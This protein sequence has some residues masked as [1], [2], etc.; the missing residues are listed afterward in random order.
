MTI[1]PKLLIVFGYLCTTVLYAQ[2]QQMVDSLLQAAQSKN[3]HD[4]TKIKAYNDLGIQYA[5]TDSELARVYIN[6]ALHLAKQIKKER[7]IAGAHNCLG[8]VHYYQKEYDSA[9]VR[10]ETALKINK[11]L[12]HRWGQASALN[13]IGAVQNHQNKY[14]EAIQSFQ[15]A[16]EIFKATG[17]SLAL[18]KSIENR[19]V[20]YNLM[21]HRQKA[22]EYFFNA[23]Q[24]YEKVNNDIGIGRGYLQ[25]SNLFIDQ[26]EYKKGLEYLNEALPKV[27]AGGNKQYIGAIL[28]NMAVCYKGLKE[29]EKALDYFQEALQQKKLTGNKKTLASSQSGIGTTYFEKGDYDKAIKYQKEALQNY[30]TKGSGKNKVL[31]NN[32]IARSYL[33][34]KKPDSAKQYVSRAID[35]T[36]ALGYLDGEKE[37]SHILGLI[38]EQEGKIEQALGFYKD[39]EQLKD[40]V[41][42]LENEKRV[43]EL[44][45]I[46]ETEK[47]EQKIEFLE[48]EAEINSL[49]RILLIS[50][51]LLSV[52]IFGLGFYGLRQKV[53]RNQ[54]EKEKLDRELAFKK[55]E[56]TTHTLQ[57]VK[58]NEVLGKLKQ[59][60]EELQCTENASNGYQQ[61]VRTIDFDLMNDNH[62]ENFARYF[63]EVHKDFNAIIK[64]K[65]PDVTPNELRLMALLKMNLSSKEMANILNIS[66]DGIK[67]ARQRLRKKMQ[68]SPKDSLETA[69]LEI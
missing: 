44:Q 32:A 31:T 69:I 64:Q 3:T 59:K 58:K 34:I 18:A 28:H 57:I 66:A 62:W 68:L 26:K 1:F 8:I 35:I 39:F 16:G 20:S 51:L 37:A 4:T 21:G 24:L 55:K 56:L 23:I 22:T 46:Y 30:T 52:I 49:Q 6:K 9:L 36:K 25:I 12:G 38:A 14:Y 17:D 61:L 50:G 10:F 53:K 41:Y 60:V 54:L 48:Q 42:T 40:S 7:G 27:K 2:N 33:K 47:K 13:Q 29:Y 19:G 67:K 43:R 63:E 11:E 65:F 45:T 15:Q 5:P